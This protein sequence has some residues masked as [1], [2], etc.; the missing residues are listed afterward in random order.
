M[1]DEDGAQ[2]RL[3]A[4]EQAGGFGVPERMAAGVTRMRDSSECG[5]GCYR[6]GEG[7]A[8]GGDGGAPGCGVG[9]AEPQHAR[10]DQGTQPAGQDGRMDG[11]GQA[12]QAERG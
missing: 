1:V 7:E 9:V 5:T 8:E 11:Q 3:A 2:G 6:S 12:G 10:A 4:P